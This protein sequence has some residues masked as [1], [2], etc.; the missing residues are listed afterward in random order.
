LTINNYTKYPQDYTLRMTVDPAKGTGAIR[1]V[2]PGQFEDTIGLS[3][4][5]TPY[6]REVTISPNTT[7]EIQFS[8]QGASLPEGE[9]SRPRGFRLREFSVTNG[10]SSL[11]WKDIL[12]E[13]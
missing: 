10:S 9:D 2:L 8:A 13:M 1:A 12:A 7:I 4:E 6:I 11:L 3:E 5:G